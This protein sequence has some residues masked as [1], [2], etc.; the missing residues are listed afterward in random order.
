MKTKIKCLLVDDEPI[1]RDI[2][3]TYI[4]RLPFL[5]LSAV[6]EDAIDAIH[7]LSDNVVDI[8]FSDIQMPNMNGLDFIKSLQNKPAI[9][10]VT[11]YNEYAIEGFN[12]GVVDF[13]SKPIEFDRFVLAVN[14]A[15]D[16]LNKETK[17]VPEDRYSSQHIFIK[18][19]GKNIRVNFS[20]IIF[21]ESEK[22][23]V[24]VH[25]VQQEYKTLMTLKSI[26]NELDPKIF[27]KIQRSYIINLDY[28]HSF[29]GNLI[30]LTNNKK[31]TVSPEKK[32]ELFTILNIQK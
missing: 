19:Q 31:L 16:Y 22:D 15:V 27:F 4:S 24:Y 2:I 25:T 10:Y 12:I 13:I 7:Y 8:I 1:S 29:T 32:E 18:S 30:E 17:P 14:R 5:E 6:C 23:Y 21:I 3:E 28:I 11:A 20:D 9:I 26:E